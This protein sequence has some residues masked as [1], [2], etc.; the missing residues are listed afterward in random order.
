MEYIVCVTYLFVFLMNFFVKIFFSF[1]NFLLVINTFLNFPVMDVY[2]NCMLCVFVTYIFTFL[3]QFMLHFME[4][5]IMILCFVFLD[6][7]SFSTWVPF[8]VIT[9]TCSITYCF[10]NFTMFYFIVCLLTTLIFFVTRCLF[11]IYLV[12]SYYLDILYT[13][14]ILGNALIDPVIILIIV[15]SYVFNFLTGLYTYVYVL[16]ISFLLV[17]YVINIYFAF[18]VFKVCC[19]VFNVNYMFFVKYTKYLY[20][21]ETEVLILCFRFLFFDIFFVLLFVYVLFII[22]FFGFFV[23][24]FLFVSI[25]FCFSMFLHNNYVCMI[26]FTL[27]KNLHLKTQLYYINTL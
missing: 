16:C 26:N 15:F 4:L 9:N 13:I 7:I 19:N 23:K 12:Y 14:N 27:I 8:C 6:F 18:S 24:D 11:V 3:T 25:F 17:F 10:F 21:L 20:T 5:F 2:V 1:L 22:N